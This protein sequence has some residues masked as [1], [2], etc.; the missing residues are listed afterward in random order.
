M[1]LS[2][3]TIEREYLKNAVA[4]TSLYNTW[5]DCF[6]CFFGGMICSLIKKVRNVLSYCS[7]LF[8]ISYGHVHNL[9]FQSAALWNQC[10]QKQKIRHFSRICCCVSDKH[11][12]T[13]TEQV[14]KVSQE[15]GKL[16][17]FLFFISF[18]MQHAF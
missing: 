3:H 13:N 8:I 17:F 4:Q 5:A 9:P 15:F 7:N 2:A 18:H 10:K 1:M 12:M 16:V 6:K 11:E 14:N